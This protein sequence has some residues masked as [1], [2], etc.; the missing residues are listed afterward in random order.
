MI[1]AFPYSVSEH[2]KCLLHNPLHIITTGIVLLA[3]IAG[4]LVVSIG[5]VHVK[6]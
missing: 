5:V 1:K 6:E 4:V 3:H 2:T